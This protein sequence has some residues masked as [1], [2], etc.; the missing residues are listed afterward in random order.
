MLE[1]CNLRGG[2][3]AISTPP[4]AARRSHLMK[5]KRREILK[6]MSEEIAWW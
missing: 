6:K 2:E 3:E 4:K 5:G 1:G